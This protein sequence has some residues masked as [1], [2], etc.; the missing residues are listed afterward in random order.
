[1]LGDEHFHYGAAELVY[2]LRLVAYHHAVGH[3]KR[4][5]GGVSTLTLDLDDTHPAGGIGFHTR[6]IA[7]IRQVN[8]SVNGRLQDHLAGLGGNLYPV[9]CDGDVVGHFRSLQSCLSEGSR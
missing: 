8:S 7:Q 1:M 3:R 9:N 6:V 2:F 4:A 5:G